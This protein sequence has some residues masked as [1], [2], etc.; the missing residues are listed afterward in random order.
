MGTETQSELPLWGS[1]GGQ[2]K[3]E[4]SLRGVGAYGVESEP[5]SS[6]SIAL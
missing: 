1:I 4:S 5:E 3:Q 2:I 6:S